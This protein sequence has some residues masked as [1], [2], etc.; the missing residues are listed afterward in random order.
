MNDSEEPLG[1]TPV[2]TCGI[3]ILREA[4]STCHWVLA[5]TMGDSEEPELPLSSSLSLPDNK[6]QLVDQFFV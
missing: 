4:I 5:A 1:N 6:R 2:D 3:T